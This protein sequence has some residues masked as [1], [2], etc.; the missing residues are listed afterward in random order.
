MLWVS[1]RQ[2]FQHGDAGWESYAEWI[3]LQHLRE[4]RSLDSWL[5][6]YVND[7]GSLYC[8]VSQVGSVLQMLPRPA[9]ER[10]YYLLGRLL[11]SDSADPVD[12]FD[13]LGC[14]LSDKTMTSSVPNCGPWRGGLAPFVRRLNS[15]RLL[16]VS[17]ARRVQ[18]ILPVEWPTNPHATVQIWALYGR[19]S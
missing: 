11:E 14:D 7:C 9:T 16:S 5:N 19:A 18:E 2:R 1:T 12:G 4:V 15:V 10:E 8:D 13:F 17:D 6:K 3:G